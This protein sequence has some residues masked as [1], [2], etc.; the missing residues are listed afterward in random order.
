MICHSNF[1]KGIMQGQKGFLFIYLFFIIAVVYCT[2][3]QSLSYVSAHVILTTTL[4]GKNIIIPILQMQKLRLREQN[5]LSRVRRLGNIRIRIGQ[6]LTSFRVCLLAILVVDSLPSTSTAGNPFLHTA[7]SLA[8]RQRL[9]LILFPVLSGD[10]TP[11]FPSSR[12]SHF[13]FSILYT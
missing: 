6:R 5:N 3:C 1:G 13:S 10:L 2:L 12:M 4:Q 8:E 11:G 9:A 7:I